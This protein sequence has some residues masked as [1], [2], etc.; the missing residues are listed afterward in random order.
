MPDDPRVLDLVDRYL[1]RRD[2]IKQMYGLLDDPARVGEV[3]QVISNLDGDLIDHLD[4]ICNEICVV[5]DVPAAAVTM[6]DGGVHIIAGASDAVDH[7]KNPRDHSLCIFVAASGTQF[8]MSDLT[9]EDLSC[10]PAYVE[11][12][13]RAYLGRPLVVRSQPVGAL[14]LIDF[15]ARE[16]TDVEKETLTNYAAHVSGILEEKT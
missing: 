6:V 14:C 16:W 5:L 7:G 4:V 12:N 15:I 9:T 13:I 11:A 1:R 3:Q 2:D 10:L 8:D